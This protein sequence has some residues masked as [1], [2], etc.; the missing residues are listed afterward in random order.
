VVAL[1]G[2][3]VGAS[4]EAGFEAGFETGFEAGVGVGI[5]AV[6]AAPR[7]NPAGLGEEDGLA[8]RRALRAVAPSLAPVETSCL[9]IWSCIDHL[10][11]LPAILREAES[12]GYSTPGGAHDN[13]RAARAGEPR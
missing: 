12:S 9:L 11:C 6:S 1:G 4:F 3:G 5:W 2:P 13:P 8:I 7:A 10:P